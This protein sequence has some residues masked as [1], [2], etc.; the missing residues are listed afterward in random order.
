VTD[1]SKVSAGSRIVGYLK[2]MTLPML[3][4]DVTTNDGGPV[5]AR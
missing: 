4:G 3:T 5:A 1:L 2:K